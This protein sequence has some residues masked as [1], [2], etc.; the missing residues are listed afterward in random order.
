MASS[1]K[2]SATCKGQFHRSLFSIAV[3]SFSLY[4]VLACGYLAIATGCDADQKI[5][6]NM[7]LME[8]WCHQVLSLSEGKEQYE[9]LLEELCRLCCRNAI[10]AGYI[11]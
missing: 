6:L 7:R 10:V 9:R 11:V 1:T 3:F 8:P 4:L 2:R 5:Y